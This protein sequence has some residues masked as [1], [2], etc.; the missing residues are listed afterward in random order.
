MEYAL[1]QDVS[2]D[3]VQLVD[4]PEEAAELPPLSDELLLEWKTEKP[5]Y[6]RVHFMRYILSSTKLA[7]V[8]FLVKTEDEPERIS[9]IM[10]HKSILKNKSEFF[11]ALFS[12]R[13][14]NEEV[15]LREADITDNEFRDFLMVRSRSSTYV[16]LKLM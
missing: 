2:Q 5:S 13:W 6:G 3:S 4:S 1:H 12:D 8:T 15:D 14:F 10:A 7:D 16:K 11:S 9:R